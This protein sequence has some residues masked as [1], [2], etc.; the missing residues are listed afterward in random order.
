MS[1]L[2]R[3]FIKL[4]PF[5]AIAKDVRECGLEIKQLKISGNGV[6][7]TS[8]DAILRTDSAKK[9]IRALKDVK[10]KDHR[11]SALG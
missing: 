2:K 9:Q 7:S 4:T 1:R 10:L 6:V 5:K 3:L 11:A 8:F